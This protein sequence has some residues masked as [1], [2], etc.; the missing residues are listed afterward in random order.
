MPVR[1]TAALGVG[2]ASGLLSAAIVT[3]YQMGDVPAPKLFGYCVGMRMYGV[4]RG[5]DAALYLFPG[6]VFGVFFGA[7][8]RRRR[9]G[10]GRLL[11]F[12]PASGVANAVAVFLCIWLAD[13]LPE[14]LHVDSVVLPMALAGA[15]SG[16]VGGALLS[17]TATALSL[18][19][20]LRRSVLAAAALGLLVPLVVVWQVVGTLLFYAIWQGG[21]AAALGASVT[22]ET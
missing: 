19:L 18:G 7:L 8:E 2:I 15:I 1:A 4:C 21:Y 12:L 22:S 10:F 5:V 9:I 6:S 20:A 14:I 13:R 17:G 16:A 3:S 11:V